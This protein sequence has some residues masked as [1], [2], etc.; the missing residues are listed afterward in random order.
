MDLA[1][2]YFLGLLGSLHCAAMCGPLMLALPSTGGSAGRF[3][4]GR[5][6]YQLGR[7]TMYCLL[8]V[9]AGLAGR[10]LF[11]AGLQR[12][13]SLALGAAL[14]AG[15]ILSRKVAVSAPV[16][17]L[18][19]GLKTAMSAQLR[20]RT[21][22]SLILLGMLNGLLPCGLVYVALAGA[23]TRGTLGAGVGYMALFGLGTLPMLLA[24]SFSGRLFP[25]A[26][27]MKLRGAIPAGV[28]LLAALLILR[29]L[30]LG[31]PYV[32]PTLVAGL[33]AACCAH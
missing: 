10:S 27:R 22:S 13:L 8:G 3:I 9:L 25:V 21:F 12:G 32:S 19:G 31:I 17:R 33:P 30:A 20:R 11:L 14:L 26:R 24:I 16:V 7:I 1:L 18:V 5:I 29:G 4:A 15:L 6:S 28:C 2:A 23:V